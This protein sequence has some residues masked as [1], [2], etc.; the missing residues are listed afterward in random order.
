MDIASARDKIS[1]LIEKYERLEKDDKLKNYNEENTKNEF[2][3]PLLGALGWDVRNQETYDEVIKEE[4]VLKGRVDYALRLNGVNRLFI[5]AKPFK[6]DMDNDTW[7]RQVIEY[8]YNQG[9]AFV[10]LTNFEVLRIY[11]SE[12]N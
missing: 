8:G 10:V 3:E 1:K 12:W 9:V 11:N 6:T 4:K 2:I 7:A 5:E